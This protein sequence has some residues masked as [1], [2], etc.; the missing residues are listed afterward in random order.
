MNSF[1]Y[2][3]QVFISLACVVFSVASIS[4][5]ITFALPLPTPPI[6]CEVSTGSLSFNGQSDYVSL[7]YNLDETPPFSVLG[8][9]YLKQYGDAP[10]APNYAGNTIL[11]RGDLC[12]SDHWDFIF[13]V[14]G[15]QKLGFVTHPGFS[16]RDLVA[17]EDDFP[18]GEWVMVAFT[19]QSTIGRLYQNDQLVDT[20]DSMRPGNYYNDSPMLL[21]A[22]WHS[23]LDYHN[24]CWDGYMDDIAVY[25]RVLSE[26]EIEAIYLNKGHPATGL[27]YQ[28][29]CNEG[30]GATMG[31]SVGGNDGT[32]IGTS[33]SGD[34]RPNDPCATPSPTPTT[35]P[36]VTPTP[37]AKPS[38]TPTPTIPQPTPPVQCE[39]STGCLNFDGQTDH[40]VS[41]SSNID[42]T[43]YFS[44]SAWVYLDQY[45]QVYEFAPPYV[46]NIILS[47]G[48]LCCS[49]QW[50][51]LFLVN[52]DRKL[53]F[54]THPEFC[55]ADK[56]E[57]EDL[58]PL[59]EWVFVTFTQ[60]GL[61][62]KLYQNGQ[63]VDVN[64]N[65]RTGNAHNASPTLLGARWDSN[66]GK[67]YTNP[68]DGFIDDIAIYNTAL[69]EEEIGEIYENKGYPSAGLISQWKCNEGV[70]VDLGDSVA[71]N[72]GTLIETSW[73]VE[74]RP[75]DPCATPTPTTVQPSPTPTCS[76]CCGTVTPTP[77]PPAPTPQCPDDM[78]AYWRADGDVTDYLGNHDGTL[79][80]GAGFG[81]GVCESAFSFNDNDDYVS[82][83]AS[84]DF[85]LGRY[86][87]KTM[88]FWWK[89][90]MLDTTVI[91]ISRRDL[92]DSHRGLVLHI[93][94]SEYYLHLRIN[95]WAKYTV[96]FS[97]GEWYH[98]V[99]TKDD[100]DW[101]LY[102][103][104]QKLPI[105]SSMGWPYD[106]DVTKNIPFLIGEDGALPER[107]FPGLID[108]VVLYNRAL[109]AD[110]ALVLYQSSCNYCVV[111]ATPTPP[112][113]DDSMVAYW[114][115]DGDAA[116]CIGNN[117]GILVNNMTFSGGVCEEG[118][119]F[120]EGSGN[121]V[122]IG[123]EKFDEI[124]DGSV[125]F[126][127]K[128]DTLEP[129]YHV[130]YH[131]QRNVTN[132][133][134][135]FL[136][137]DDYL[138]NV[139]L[140]DGT[141]Y[142][143]TCASVDTGWHHVVGTFGEEG[144]RLY[145]DGALQPN[146]SPFTG[147]YDDIG[148]SVYNEL[149]YQSPW[150]HQFH[151]LMDEVAIY[152]RIL[153]PAEVENHYYNS[154]HY[155]EPGS[156]PIPVPS[157][158]P[159]CPEGMLA[160][161]Q[162]ENNAEDS[163]GSCNGNLM[164]GASFAAG[165]VDRSFSLDGINDHINIGDPDALDIKSGGLTLET[166][167]KFS[168]LGGDTGQTLI[169]KV[170]ADSHQ[171][172]IFKYPPDVFGGKLRFLVGNGPIWYTAYASG[173]TLVP[174]QWYHVAGTWDQVSG[175]L[176]IY[177]NGVKYTTYAD[178]WGDNYINTLGTGGD[179][180]LGKRG[181]SDGR[182]LRGRLD[183]VAIYDRPLPEN[184]ILQHY[185]NAEHYCANPPVLPPT[186]PPGPTATPTVQPP[187]T[188]P[189]TIPPSMT[190]IPTPTIPPAP[191]I[192]AIA[193]PILGPAPLTV[194]FNAEFIQGGNIQAYRWDFD[195]DGVWDY[196]SPISGEASHTFSSEGF[197][198]AVCAATDS[199]GRYAYDFIIIQVT[200]PPHQL[201]VNASAQPRSGPAPL[202]LELGGEVQSDN[203]IVLYLW[204]FED[205]GIFD[206]GSTVDIDAGHI[207]PAQGD[208][209]ARIV[210]VDDLGLTA[211]DTVYIQ[212]SPQ[213]QPPLVEASA[214]PTSGTVPLR[215]EFSGNGYPPESIVLYEWDFDGDGAFDW[216]SQTAGECDHTYGLVGEY[217]PIFRATDSNGLS[218]R[219]SVRIS[220][221]TSSQLKVWL[222][223]PRDGGA[224]E[225]NAVTVR[226]NTAPGSLT[227]WVKLQYKASGAAVWTEMATPIYPPPYSFS[228]SWDTTSLS[229]GSYNIRAV[230]SDTSD[231][232][233]DSDVITVTVVQYNPEISESI[234]GEGDRT[235]REIISRE[236]SALIEITGG[237]SVLIPYGA[238]AGEGTV[239]LKDGAAAPYG[240]AKSRSQSDLFSFTSFELEGTSGLQK[241]ALLSISYPDDDFDGIVDGTAIS[242][243]DLK[244]FKY[245]DP[246]AEWQ[247]LPDCTVFHE[248]N[249][250]QARIISE[251]EYALGSLYALPEMLYLDSGDY[252]GD[253][254]SDIGIFR[255]GTGLWAV[256]GITRVYF[257]SGSDLP[258]S[259]DYNGDGSS[260]IA[261]YRSGFGLWA[262][263]NVTRSYF[264]GS[265]DIP[266]PGDFDGDG[267][268]DVGI[269]RAGSGLW[270][271]QGVTR[272]YFGTSG[273]TAVPGNFSGGP[274]KDIAIFRPGSGLWA[275]RGVTRSYFGGSAD[276]PLTGDFDGDGN[277]DIGIYRAVAGLWAIRNITRGYFGGA[278]DIPVFADYLG[279]GSDRIGIFRPASGLW[280]VR[281]ITRV[282]FGTVSDLPVS[283]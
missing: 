217:R 193:R 23:D 57:A 246:A 158:T 52:W 24:F 144:V 169:G 231:N 196:S 111:I 135:I 207:Y 181:D 61:T 88:A 263:R 143:A 44:V 255:E 103:N 199:L 21:G 252:N 35:D 248:E 189:P 38:A 166:W 34:H 272:A 126:W 85:D 253:G 62:G 27:S 171:F 19:H 76:I 142:R 20:N 54:V 268:C 29:K 214:E 220:V 138:A 282:Y 200:A 66:P 194:D 114:Q 180:Y 274:A 254:T 22:T 277:C 132:R 56:V 117:D 245:N 92:S 151:G 173:V 205:D 136:S 154:C 152:S 227:K 50:D 94:P 149:G 71:G 163:Y 178:G 156:T 131:H 141:D 48:N 209:D 257:G 68:W 161:W 67:G 192:D 197:Y 43:T 218:A 82:I 273:D 269:Y 119:L 271:I 215:V 100:S 15:N 110:E 278:S 262:V 130:L 240:M 78:I 49:G 174:G 97:A 235:K 243:S 133:H 191:R 260:D 80:G 11:S 204:D 6:Q 223:Q 210:V 13:N 203:D 134:V 275:V 104:G 26:E 183:E 47:R 236:E 18:L 239:V 225:G 186:P 228:T 7:A 195:N 58:F 266:I 5:Q 74:H 122:S 222:V 270:A 87:D 172:D 53:S 89:A 201:A 69:T 116:D 81:T 165:K 267:N 226:A 276:I 265:T 233:V 109:T 93:D 127:Y 179:L 175:E 32:L 182:H 113:C 79:M 242:E 213:G 211:S 237:G 17:A 206:W 147:G 63:P 259:G 33:W 155:C 37:T 230:A 261:I 202:D 64:E 247:M 145:V 256:R 187:T 39:V 164:N 129:G 120:G 139:I 51:Y 16:D 84:T 241:P 188:P 10:G 102:H 121:Y 70:G 221:T 244:I 72:N 212:V 153:T 90:D 128:A 12:C 31:D 234:D 279:T 96:P 83:P 9:V 8:W 251:G 219:D 281:E 124:E 146:F 105:S 115:A 73:S 86:D 112:A 150:G 157:S 250:V 283:R 176:A 232:L 42:E 184:I 170:T 91:P 3:C 98:T 159:G 160:Y 25:D 224:V 198:L 208:Y 125:E 118:F 36:P 41:L 229:T 123:E 99:I 137:G 140:V 4:P 46:G 167:V 249:C 238:L 185:Q 258:V 280:A 108:E 107:G 75:N 40:C 148:T 177:V 162:A 77:T 28:W 190:P 30:S 60:D 1:K 216:S 2:F 59:Q 106:A 14:N 65:M 45:N 95:H 264:G 168:D 55:C 101:E